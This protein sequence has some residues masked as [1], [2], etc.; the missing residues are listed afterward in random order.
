ME[1][2]VA[3]ILLDYK[4]VKIEPDNPFTWVSG[5][6]SPIYCDNRILI[7]YPDAVN[8]IV[9]GFKE[10]IEDIDFDVIAGTATAGIPWASFLSYELDKPMIYIRKEPKAHGTK[11][12]IE[13]IMK[14]GQKVILV[15]DL[16]STGKSSLEAVEVIRK[17]GG[18]CD[19]T[20]SIFQYGFPIAE[21]NF[22]EKKCKL[23]SITNFQ[24]LLEQLE[25]NGDKKAEVLR[26]AKNPK[27]WR[28]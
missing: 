27:E 17:E 8:T 4:A 10:M 2:L 13:G 25:L 7:S 28:K 22:K 1:E 12:Q 3:Q 14:R 6:K 9:L 26:F 21:E 5:I 23:Q 18:I 19:L 11:S 16:V 20:V 24:I 15:E